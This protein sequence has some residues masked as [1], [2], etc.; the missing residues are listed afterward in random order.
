MCASRSTK[1]VLLPRNLHLNG[2]KV[3]RLP[4][5]PDFKVYKVMYPPRNLHLK[6]H[7][8]LRL[9]QI[10]TSRFT[11]CCACNKVHTSRS[12]KFCAS[13][14]ICK[15]SFTSRSPAKAICSKSTSKDNIKIPKCSFRLR[16][17]PISEKEAHVQKSRFTAPASEHAEDHH[18]VQSTALAAKSVHRPKPA[19]ISCACHE[20]STLDHQ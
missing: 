7:K 6:V 3:V 13:H 20:K 2:H 16:L 14:E 5:N 8:V 11:K 10:C 19:P 4:R 9:P 12:T 15:S 18:H 1:V 17:P